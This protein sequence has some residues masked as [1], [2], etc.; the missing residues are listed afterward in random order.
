MREALRQG[1]SNE[2]CCEKVAQICRG[3]HTGWGDVGQ[4]VVGAGS[5][6]SFAVN[7]PGGGQRTAAELE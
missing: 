4:H 6:G 3:T 2:A 5:L 7:T 1:Y